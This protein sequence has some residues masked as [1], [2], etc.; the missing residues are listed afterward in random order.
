MSMLRM[1]VSSPITRGIT[2]ICTPT[3][4]YWTAVVKF[5]FAL[6]FWTLKNG[7]CSVFTISARPPS[8]V[9]TRGWDWISTRSSVETS[10]RSALNST[11]SKTAPT[12]NSAS[13]PLTVFPK[14]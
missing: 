9:T 7:I 12:L 8:R 5:P 6:M 1:T 4:R 14:E 11:P 10:S 2:Y 13:V 3:S